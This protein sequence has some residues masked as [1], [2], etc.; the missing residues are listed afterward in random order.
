MM[1]VT[2][3]MDSTMTNT[4]PTWYNYR[5]HLCVNDKRTLA[6]LAHKQNMLPTGPLVK[7]RDLRDQ[8]IK[9]PF[10]T[11]LHMTEHEQPFAA[12]F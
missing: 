8:C 1:E 6:Q 3:I 4:Q 12:V 2:Y 9:S 10:S 5:K 11:T 7:M